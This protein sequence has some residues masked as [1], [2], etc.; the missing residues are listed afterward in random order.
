MEPENITIIDY[1]KIFQDIK[2]EGRREVVE[3]I[4]ARYLDEK[5]VD[6]YYDVR[7]KDVGRTLVGKMR[8]LDYKDWKLQ[9]KDWGI[10][11]ES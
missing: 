5:F 6:H 8:P 7:G 2:Q 3:W 9:L 1:Q 11:D 4:N 10:D